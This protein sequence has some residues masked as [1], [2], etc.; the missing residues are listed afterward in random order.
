M[1]CVL[2]QKE[3]LIYKN[4]EIKEEWRNNDG[5]LETDEDIHSFDEEEEVKIIEVLVTV[6]ETNKGI[7]PAFRGVTD[8]GEN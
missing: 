3:V 8:N 2:G 6:S 5:A 7:L 1:V 4:C